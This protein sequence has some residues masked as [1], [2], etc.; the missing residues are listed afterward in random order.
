LN[1][2]GFKKSKV[3]F[4]FP[5]T[6]IKELKKKQKEFK[7]KAKEL[8]LLSQPRAKLPWISTKKWWPHQAR[9]TRACTRT[10][11]E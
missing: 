10:S 9:S 4:V 1:S 3:G 8:F 11:S 5:G 2:R 7:K 6:D